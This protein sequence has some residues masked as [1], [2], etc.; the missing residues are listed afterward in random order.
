MNISEWFFFTYGSPDQ[1][2]VI[3]KPDQPRLSDKNLN[4]F[5]LPQQ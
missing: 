3:D 2:G 5:F 1:E 4:F